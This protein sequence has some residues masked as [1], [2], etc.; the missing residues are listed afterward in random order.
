VV[1]PPHK[2]I[3]YFDSLSEKNN[4]KKRK[5]CQAE[6]HLTDAQVREFFPEKKPKFEEYI[7]R[8]LQDEHRDKEGKELKIQEWTCEERL[9]SHTA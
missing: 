5:K 9:F 3:Y 8:Y 1:D 7:K 4:K 2:K 6:H